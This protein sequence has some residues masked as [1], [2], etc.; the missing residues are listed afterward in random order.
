MHRTL[1]PAQAIARDERRARFS[2]LAKRIGALSDAERQALIDRIGI[3]VTIEG[4][5]ISLH[6]ACMV[7]CQCPTATVLGGYRQWQAAQ[8]QV[9]KGEHGLMI[10]A[11]TTRPEDPNRQPGE[12]SSADRQNFVAVTVF[13]IS[14]TEPLATERS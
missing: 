9:R 5:A 7:A 10:W 11:P 1:S 2:E 12:V 13:D 8:R 6:N 14:Q 3:L 4:R